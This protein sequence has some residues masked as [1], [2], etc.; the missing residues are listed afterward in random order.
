MVLLAYKA[1]T[2]TTNISKSLYR[3]ALVNSLLSISSIWQV[4]GKAFTTV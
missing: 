4:V 2:Y 3:A 1:V